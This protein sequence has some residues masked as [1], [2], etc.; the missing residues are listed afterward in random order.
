M[1]L[2]VTWIHNMWPF[3]FHRWIQCMYCVLPTEILSMYSSFF[4][5][6]NPN[7]FSWKGSN[8]NGFNNFF[9]I[10]MNEKSSFRR[11]YWFLFEQ[12]NKKYFFLVICMMLWCFLEMFYLFKHLS[13]MLLW[14]LFKINRYSKITISNV[15]YC[16]IAWHFRHF[17]VILVVYS[18]FVSIL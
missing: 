4:L 11:K 16:L 13:M 17:F 18:T 15:F 1:G 10:C 8:H 3:G 6:D 5:S 12:K 7:Y 9:F 14:M 2:W